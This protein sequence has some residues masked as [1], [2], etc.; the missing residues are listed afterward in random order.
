VNTT[1]LR[2][3][4]VAGSNERIDLLEKKALLSALWLFVLLNHI[5]RAIHEI[6]TAEFLADALNG[7]YNG[8]ELTEAMFLLGGILIEVPILTMLLVWV[9]PL[10]ANRWANVI[11]APLYGLTVILG[12][13]GDLDDYFHA[14]L[15]LIALAIIVWQAW[16]WKPSNS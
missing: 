14:S 16:S 5:F 11:V 7:T 9:L 10:R 4:S 8:Q 1:T 12:E 15:E 2:R 13:L 3:D 6:V